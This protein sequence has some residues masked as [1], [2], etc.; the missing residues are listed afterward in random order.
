MKEKTD[1]IGLL[2]DLEQRLKT[3]ETR[4]TIYQMTVGDASNYVK[5]IAT[6]AT[7]FAGT[8]RPWRDE[9]SDAVSLQQTGP[10]VSRSATESSVEFTTASNL[11]DYMFCNVQLNHD[12][13]LT[14]SIYPHIHYWQAQNN[15]PNFLLQYR[16]QTNLGTKVTG[17]TNLKCNTNATAYTTGTI[18]NIALSLPIA[19]PTGTTLSDVVQFRILRDNANTSTVFTGADPYTTTVGITAFDVHFAINSIGSS[20]EYTK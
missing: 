16:W 15:I 18:N 12:K 7:T 1:L 13:D 9:L 19:V 2:Q 11:S 8:A 14:A 10:S 17:W 20:S 6:G 3:L 4:T 5:M